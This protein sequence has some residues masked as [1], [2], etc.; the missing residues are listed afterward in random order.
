VENL[1][2]PCDETAGLRKGFLNLVAVLKLL[3]EFGLS[4]THV[5]GSGWYMCCCLVR[6]TV[7]STNDY[8]VSF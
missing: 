7:L 8:Y 4:E 5:A 6:I 2:H 1:R 3:L